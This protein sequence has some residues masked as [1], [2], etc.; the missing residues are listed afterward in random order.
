MPGRQ[1]GLQLLQQL[2]AHA[3]I[4]P[5]RAHKKRKNA[6]VFRIRNGKAHTHAFRLGNPCAFILVNKVADVSGGLAGWS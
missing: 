4:L 2:L 5:L 6:A 3:F 1:K